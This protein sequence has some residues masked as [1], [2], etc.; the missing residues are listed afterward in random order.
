MGLRKAAAS[1]GLGFT[2]L[3]MHQASA[4]PHGG[5][6]VAN[7]NHRLE[8]ASQALKAGDWKRARNSSR[9]L[10]D[11]MCNRI[12]EGED[13]NKALGLTLTFLALGEAGL[14]EEDDARWHWHTA[15]GFFPDAARFDLSPFGAPG[16]WLKDQSLIA[17]PALAASLGATVAVHPLPVGG[18]IQPPVKRFA[19]L[20]KYPAAMRQ[21]R[22]EVVV[23]VS[24]VIDPRGKVTS[25]QILQSSGAPTMVLA[26]LEAMRRWK[27]KPATLHGQP[28]AV[29]YTMVVNYQL[30][31]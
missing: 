4:A 21:Q 3:L 12:V 30:R 20:P 1:I 16:A 8:A 9:K 17:R 27:F 18:E 29:F 22:R 5:P 14:G 31:G 26:T 2:F 10:L 25:P 23:I 7:W 24:A 19:Q 11:E 28:V 15:L 13:V 6:V